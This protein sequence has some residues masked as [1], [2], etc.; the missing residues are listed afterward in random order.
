MRD[1]R[2]VGNKVRTAVEARYEGYH[3]ER[4]VVEEEGWQ[5]EIY[6]CY[7]TNLFN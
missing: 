2:R 7:A 6:D 4:D 1:Q 3:D 5:G